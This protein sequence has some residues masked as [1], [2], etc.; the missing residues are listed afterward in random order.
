LTI[1]NGA[2]VNITTA[3]TTFCQYEDGIDL[4][5]DIAGG[6]WSGD[7]ITNSGTGAFDPE[8][9]GVGTHT[10]TY[11]YFDG[12]CTTTETEDFVVVADDD[13]PVIAGC[14]D[15]GNPIPGAIGTGDGTMANPFMLSVQGGSCQYFPSWAAPTASEDCGDVVSFTNDQSPVYAA[16]STPYQITYTA[17]NETGGAA[18]TS[19]CSFWIRIVDDV[20][21]I[22]NNCPTDQLAV[23]TDISNRC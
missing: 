4:A 13:A 6:T 1:V 11:S 5:A 21:P 20:D 19:T 10:I 3:P 7:G 12:M 22:L 23:G 16:S 17:V 15:A 8:T 14:F 18:G 9:A 2:M